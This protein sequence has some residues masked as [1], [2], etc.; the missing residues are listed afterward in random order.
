MYRML[1]TRLPVEF[2]TLKPSI[3]VG[4]NDNCK[5]QTDQYNI[6]CK[7]RVCMQGRRKG[8]IPKSQKS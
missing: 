4:N 6:N 7:K 3:P 2:Q 1:R 5:K 8:T